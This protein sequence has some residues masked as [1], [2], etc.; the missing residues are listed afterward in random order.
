M[1]GFIL[2]K[3]HT[4]RR[5]TCP[6]V[7]INKNIIPQ[8][9]IAFGTNIWSRA[10]RFKKKKLHTLKLY[11][12]LTNLRFGTH[13][14]KPLY[15]QRKILRPIAAAP[16]F[17]SEKENFIYWL[18]TIDQRIS[19]VYSRLYTKLYGHNRF[20]KGY[21]HGYMSI[22]KRSRVRDFFPSTRN[23]LTTRKIFWNSI[24]PQTYSAIF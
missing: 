8:T 24:L 21:D 22:R 6:L 15:F 16:W 11:R 5:N 1:L 20:I 19:T 18:P 2:L 9:D 3:S 12:H 4:L 10:Y 17:V 7:F 23:Y 13:L 14:Q